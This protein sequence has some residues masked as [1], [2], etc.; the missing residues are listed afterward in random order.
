MIGCQQQLATPTNHTHPIHQLTQ[1]SLNYNL[2]E[3][4]TL[5][6]MTLSH[7]A[8]SSQLATPSWQTPQ[9][10]TLNCHNQT[11]KLHRYSWPHI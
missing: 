10:C 11:N 7:L 6:K 4:A 1:V 9:L 8:T 3:S 5:S 2:S